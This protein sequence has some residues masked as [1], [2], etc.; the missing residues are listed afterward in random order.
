MNSVYKTEAWLLADA[1]VASDAPAPLK[2]VPAD[3]RPDRPAPGTLVAVAQ[4]YEEIVMA[5]RLRRHE[6]RLSQLAVDEIAGLQAGYTGKIECGDKR[7]GAMSMPCI[8]GALG[9]ELAVIRTVPHEE[10]F[11]AVIA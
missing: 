1:I 11:A 6:L 7:L 10:R 3:P 4:T 8:L 2:L 5:I 9:L